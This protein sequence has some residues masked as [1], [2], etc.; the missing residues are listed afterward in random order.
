M[1][2][3]GFATRVC[4][5]ESATCIFERHRL[6]VASCKDKSEMVATGLAHVAVGGA[7]QE[8]HSCSRSLLGYFIEMTQFLERLEEE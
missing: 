4:T 6:K 2:E 1:E 8:G 7:A 3:S 5:Q